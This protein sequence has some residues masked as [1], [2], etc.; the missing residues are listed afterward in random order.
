VSYSEDDCGDV[1]CF[2]SGEG[3]D[4]LRVRQVSRQ[5]VAFPAI[6]SGELGPGDQIV[7][8]LTVTEGQ[9][10]QID[11]NA[12]D[13]VVWQTEAG[14]WTY[15]SENVFEMAPGEY[16]LV[17]RNDDDSVQPYELVPSAPTIG[18]AGSRSTNGSL[19]SGSFVT[20]VALTPNSFSVTAIPSDSQDI[21]LVIEGADCFADEGLQ[22]DGEVCYLDVSDTVTLQVEV[23]GYSQDDEFGS[24]TL[25]MD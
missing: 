25:S 12:A 22:G 4:T 20:D 5:A 8:D 13:S 15:L 10:V 7:F 16:T 14:A 1:R 18:F 19:S 17:I 2:P 11:V 21:V 9:T 3:S 23:Y 6:L 24:V